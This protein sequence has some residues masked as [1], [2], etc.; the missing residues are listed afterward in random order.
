MSN[1][2]LRGGLHQQIKRHGR[3]EIEKMDSLVKENVKCKRIHDKNSRKIQDIM[4]R[5]KLQKIDTE[6]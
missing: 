5:Q 2:N 6:K 3:K 4:K 1:K